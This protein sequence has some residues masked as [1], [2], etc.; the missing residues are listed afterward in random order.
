[1]F[2]NGHV[3]PYSSQQMA[4]YA[5]KGMVATSQPLASQAGL[6]I[7][8][9]GG[10]AIDAAI[11]TAAC[12]TVVEPTSNG[13]GGDAFA[14]VWVNGELHGLNASGPAPQG[15]SIPALKALGIDQM[16]R[17]GFIPVT[18][19][20]APSA[21]CA[22]SKRF[23]KLP[24]TEVLAP[25]IHYAEEGFPLSPTLAYYWNR[26]YQIFKQ[27]LKGEEFTNWFSTFAPNGHAP[28]LGEVWKSPNHAKTLRLIAES[29]G[30]AFYHGEL[31]DAI[32]AFSTKYGGFICKSD[33]ENY[34]PEWVKPISVNYR[35]YDVW[36]IPPNGQGLVALQ[37]LNIVKGFEFKGRDEVDTL[38]KQIEAMKL[39][40]ADGFSYITDS[41]A[42]KQNVD[43][44]LS[45]S[46]AEARRQ[47]ITDTA[48]TPTCGEPPKGGTVYLATADG[49]GNMVSFI[50]SNYMGFGSGLVVPGTGIA[51]Q[52]RGY[53]FSLDENHDNCLQPGKR[54]YH[55]IIP[56]FLTKDNQA[57]GPFSIMGGF[58]QPQGHLQIIMNTI[59]F[60]LNPQAALDAPRWQWMK[61]KSITVEQNMPNHLIKELAAKGHQVQ[62]EY[63]SGSFGRGQIIWRNPETGVLIGG[64]DSR[65]DGAIAV[66]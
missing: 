12:L 56:G 54:T 57:I 47:L 3:Y 24:L 30:E 5:T 31:A 13:I 63:N 15:L 25:A 1:M 50:Q 66:W 38:H 43:A 32:D 33:L 58:M 10:N 48:S 59:D 4:H 23:G 41:K 37:A 18:V 51:L 11:A 9:K 28:K 8:K 65:T 39:A 7:L 19:P 6:D 22:L 29:K 2:N 34:Q 44:L 36:E 17:H 49:E 27:N 14:L 45:E 21:W 40:F 55:T 20:G 26:A 46:Y 64:T 16:P 35:G 60:N 61:D 52:N 42:M 53:D 62:V